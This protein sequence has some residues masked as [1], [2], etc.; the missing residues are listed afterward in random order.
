MQSFTFH[1]PTKIK[2]GN[3]KIRDL[4]DELKEIGSET[5]LIVTDK[6]IKE[7]GILEEIKEILSE[8]GTKFEVF[9]KI[10]PNPK[11]KTIEEG[12]KFAE[13]KPIGSVTG[14]GGGSS[15]DAAKLI[16]M[17]LKN[18]GKIH[19]FIGVN[20]V[21]NRALPLITVPTTAGTGSE[22]T[23][24]AVFTDTRKALHSKETVRS[25]LLCPD[26]AIVDPEL[27]ISMG[28]KLT[29]ATGFDALT[30]AIESYTAKN[31][32]P[33]T[34]QLSLKTIDIISN[35]IV[36][37]VK[38]GED[39]NSR[40]NMSLG[41]LMAG[42]SFFNSDVTAVHCLSEA[43]G[44]FYD[45]PHGVANAVLLP[46]VMEYNLPSRPNRFAKISEKLNV[47]SRKL[48]TKEK[49]EKSVNKVKKLSD[50]VDLP[51][52]RELGIKRKDFEEISKIAEA[53]ISVK[54]NPR[55]IKA[56]DFKEILEEAYY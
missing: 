17:L 25:D 40:R 41:S 29:A 16:S 28:P 18:E 35:N 46:F 10:E 27:T 54:S 30:H 45:V 23:F 5:H 56:E 15:L 53:N 33:I 34:D 19:E 21:K 22:V 8:S 20:K 4:P 42:I 49:A 2:F 13:E 38:N 43:L 31:A 52:L 32:Q 14:L 3:G 48:S 39:I 11:D 24:S 37:A 36:R 47:T 55:P 12:V 7:T 26:T 50:E 6:G 51:K 1:T 9:S 44:G